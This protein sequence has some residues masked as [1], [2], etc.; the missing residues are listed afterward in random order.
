MIDQ[1]KFSPEANAAGVCHTGA[2]CL[3]MYAEL[4]S[5]VKAPALKMLEE[6]LSP[7][8]GE[9]RKASAQDPDNWATPYHFFWGMSVRNL[10]RQKGYG[11]SYFG[12]HNLDDI[13]ISLVKEALRLK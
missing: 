12:V 4:S 13:Y 7:V 9:I 1:N 8:A 6:E 10:L 11:E 5:E 2:E 3:Q